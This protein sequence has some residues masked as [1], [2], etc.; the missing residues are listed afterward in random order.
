M[1]SSLISAAAPRADAATLFTRWQQDGDQEARDE[2][3]RR[4]QPLA[5]KLA[6]RYVNAQEPLE[7]LVQVAYVA[8]LGAID[9]FDPDRGL[10]FS[11]F[12]VPTVLGELK[13]HFRDTGWAV[14][15]PRG[16]Q[17][18]SLRVDRAIAKLTADT[19]RPPTIDAIAQYLEVTVD[20][21]LVGME[22]GGAHYSGSLDAPLGSAGEDDVQSLGD[23]LG[24]PDP[25]FRLSELTASLRTAVSHLPRLERLALGLR[26]EDDMKQTEIAQR[27]GCSQMHVS[28]LLRRAAE[29]LREELE[30]ELG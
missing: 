6:A 22:A 20:E 16:A 28:R 17:E 7:D 15:V 12:A 11:S 25:G 9:R 23:V 19:G 5:R 26:L 24:D 8:L 14:H 1:T 30:P 4:F 29:R 18:M 27:L 21:V 13:R 3:F 10:A 2:M